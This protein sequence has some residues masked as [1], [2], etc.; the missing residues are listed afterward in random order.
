MELITSYCWEPSQNLNLTFLEQSTSHS[1]PYVLSKP[2]IPE[3]VSEDSSQDEELTESGC[4]QI[5][6][7]ISIGPDNLANVRTILFNRGTP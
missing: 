6:V 4:R 2:F 1:Q 7:R 3:E 5:V